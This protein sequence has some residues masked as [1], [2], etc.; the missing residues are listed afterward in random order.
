VSLQENLDKYGQNVLSESGTRSDQY[1]D[2]FKSLPVALLGA[3]GV[4]SSLEA[5]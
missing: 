5:C 2:Q 1:L 3:A 4:P